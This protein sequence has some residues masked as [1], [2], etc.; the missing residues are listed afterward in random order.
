MLF[1]L[2]CWVEECMF[3]ENGRN[4]RLRDMFRAKSRVKSYWEGHSHSTLYWDTQQWWSR[5]KIFDLKKR[6]CRWQSPWYCKNCILLVLNIFN[7]IIVIFFIYF[8]NF[9]LDW[10]CIVFYY[11]LY[12]I[13]I[14]LFLVIGYVINSIS[15]VKICIWWLKG[16]GKKKIKYWHYYN[17]RFEILWT[18]K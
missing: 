3:E 8:F 17:W 7:V 2:S 12:C 15:I 13:W 10:F 16:Q 11:V 5:F 1:F 6:S 9:Y 4:G 18:H 14:L